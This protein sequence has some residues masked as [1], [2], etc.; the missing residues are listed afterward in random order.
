[1]DMDVDTGRHCALAAASEIGEQQLALYA[2]EYH[3]SINRRLGL[4][5]K[6][7]RHVA[8]QLACH[9]IPQQHE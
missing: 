6:N 8:L 4:L 7:T 9:V 3:H 5:E 1:M 2:K